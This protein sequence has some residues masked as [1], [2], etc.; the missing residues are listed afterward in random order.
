MLY[1]LLKFLPQSA[2]FYIQ[3]ENLAFST[4]VAKSTDGMLMGFFSIFTW[5]TGFG[6]SCKLSP[7]GDNVHG[8]STP[9]SGKNKKNVLKCHLLKFL[10]SRL[11]ISMQTIIK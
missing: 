6:I 1:C 2:K 8:M 3:N 9:I 11:R 7:N 4:L 5:K 10:P